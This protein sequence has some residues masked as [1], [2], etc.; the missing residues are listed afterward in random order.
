MGAL[1][2]LTLG[3]GLLLIWRRGPRTPRRATGVPGWAARRGEKLRQAG[4]DGVGTAQVLG[5]QLVC[6]L[7]ALGAVELMTAT[8]TVAACFGV[9]AFFAAV[10]AGGPPAI[11]GEE[12][13]WALK[14]ANTL[15]DSASQ[16][17]PIE[18][19]PLEVH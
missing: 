16:H 14:L 10:R 13:L 6:A 17:R 5:A 3:L 18:I 4:V 19:Q 9:F 15:L 8:I 11:T 7:A 1:L 12:G 2:G